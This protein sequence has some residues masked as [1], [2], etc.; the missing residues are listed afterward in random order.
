MKSSLVLILTILSIF[1][2]TTVFAT[3]TSITLISPSD[4]TWTNDNTPSFT[5]KA[6][7]SSDS[8]FS[9][10]LIIDGINIASNSSVVNNTNTV[11]TSGVLTE[12]SHQWNI[13]CSDSMGVMTSDTRTINVDTQNPQITLVSPF[14]GSSFSSTEVDFKFRATDNLDTSLSCELYVDGEK[15]KTGIVSN[16]TQVT[17]TLTLTRDIHEWQVK[18]KDNANNEGSS[19]EWDFEITSGAGDYCSEGEQGDLTATIEEPEEDDTINAG[20]NVSIRVEVTNDYSDQLDIIV[21]AQL[22]DLDEDD[23]VVTVTKETAIDE[24]S[25][26]TIT[27]YLKAPSTVDPNNDFI[28]R[29]KAYEDGNEDNQCSEDYVNID[30]EKKEHSV[31][32]NDFSLSP[33]NVNC[34]GTFNANVD[35]SNEG[36]NP[37]DVRITIKNSELKIDFLDGL[38]LDE[39]EDYQ[40]S[41]IFAV[42]KDVSEK[43]YNIE[44][45]VY[46][47]EDYELFTSAIKPLKVEGNCFVEQKDASLNLQQVSDAFIGKEFTVKLTITNTGNVATTYTISA[48][49]YELW[50]TLTRIEPENLTIENGSSGYAYII[51][52]PLENAT[53]NQSFKVKVSFG[54]I[55]KEQTITVDIRKESAAANWL[56]QLSFE[57]QRNWQWFIVDALLIA[58][59]IVLT[60]FLIRARIENKKLSGNYVPKDI[61][62]VKI[63]SIKESEF[64]VKK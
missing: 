2:L 18:C 9:C 64:K 34:G 27:L 22:Y 49:D 32:I 4:N 62:K 39:G 52:A 61:P 10:D 54:A 50:A 6:T 20:E 30:V 59:I 21:K 7:S 14:D 13:S 60:I 5:F 31:V 46:Y 56:E 3:I 58:A 12:G 53:G 15:E 8:T 57:L 38:L 44:M 43:I 1:V 11:L 35:I 42:P 55:S 25:T 63:R 48:S 41:F 40:D 16:N 51:L 36:S 29:V 24:D 19:A 45:R 28:I 47:G 17:W 26:K 37:E 23:D 33:T